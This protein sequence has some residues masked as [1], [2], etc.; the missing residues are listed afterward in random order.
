MLCSGC[1]HRFIVDLDWIDR[2]EQSGEACPRCGLTCECEDAP[3]VTVDPGDPALDNEWVAQFHWYHTSTQPDWPTRDFD[4]ATDLTPVTRARMGGDRRVAEWAARQQG[5]ALHVGTYEA[6]MHNMFRR[7]HDQADRGSQF[8]LY[9]LHL[10]P[11]VVL[12][13]GWLIDPSNWLGDIVLDEVCPPG[14]DVARYLNYHEDPGGLS[15]ALGRGAVAEVQQVA[16]PLP[17]AWDPGWVEGA[18]ATLEKASDV[19]AAATGKL[20]RC[21]RPSS[22]RADLGRELA[23]ALAGNLP[24]N[25]HDQVES[26]TVFAEGDDPGLW[27]RR[28]S[29]L[30]ELIAS[31][32][33]VL[34]A[35]DRTP[36]RQV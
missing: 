22:P 3:R 1:G 30:F 8:Y 14:V 24:I 25:L 16:V 10:K 11:S 2:W 33:S 7:M 36:W 32:G 34:A 5:K 26:S 15:L 23:A 21:R 29:G 4:P 31:P 35:L 28:T 9:R 18:V 6:A 13:A 17:D 19:P 27:A 20:A 12:R